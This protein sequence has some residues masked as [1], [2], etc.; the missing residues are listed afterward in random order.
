[1]ALQLHLRIN[2]FL[3]LKSGFCPVL[4]LGVD[5]VI[6]CLREIKLSVLMGN[7]DNLTLVCM[8]AC[9]HLSISFL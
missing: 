1:M 6:K 2:L 7:L 9:E 3:L 4:V 5:D 8:R